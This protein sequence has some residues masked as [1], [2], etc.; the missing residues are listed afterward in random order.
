MAHLVGAA[1]LGDGDVGGQGRAAEDAQ[2][3]G[4]DAVIVDADGGGDAA[5]GLEFNNV[6][7]AVRKRERVEF[8]AL[9]AGNGQHRG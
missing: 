5:G 2:V 4:R 6:P 9:A 1:A 8:V 7:L 3:D